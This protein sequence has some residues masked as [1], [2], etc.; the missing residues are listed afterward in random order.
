V[1]TQLIKLEYHGGAARGE[2]GRT[3]ERGRSPRDTPRNERTEGR[4]RERERERE[5]SRRRKS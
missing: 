2:A 1:Y 5:E 3:W 4:K